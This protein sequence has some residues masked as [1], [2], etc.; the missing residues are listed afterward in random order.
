MSVCVDSDVYTKFNNLTLQIHVR[1][2]QTEQ[3]SLF[4]IF[5]HSSSL[6]KTV[7]SWTGTGEDG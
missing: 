6:R 4:D 7:F 5:Q 3:V 1:A 2:E